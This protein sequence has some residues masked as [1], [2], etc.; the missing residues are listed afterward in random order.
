[1]SLNRIDRR[2]FFGLAAAGMLAAGGIS[3]AQAQSVANP[4]TPIERLNATLLTAMKTGR[5]TPFEQRFN[6]V[7]A[8]ID[9]VFD[10]D[11]VLQNSIGPHWAT[12]SADD[13]ALLKV[14]FRRYTVANYVANFDDYTGQTFRVSSETRPLGNGDQI[15][16]TQLIPPNGSATTLSYVMRPSAGGWRAIDVLADGTISRVAVQRS[17]FRSL[18]SNGGSHA[19]MSSL[20]RKVVDLSGG[21][22]A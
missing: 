19:L 5:S 17:D 14:A 9:Q 1:M 21:V 7:A 8:A 10:L 11:V 3:T 18:L 20:N 13:Q 2:A 22:L 4:A 12:L 16:T 15:V 6:V